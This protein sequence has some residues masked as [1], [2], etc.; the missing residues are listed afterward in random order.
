MAREGAAA[1]AG[2]S[3][4]GARQPLEALQGARALEGRT[5]R[6][7]ARS[8]LSLRRRGTL[9]Q[10]TL[11]GQEVTLLAWRVVMGSRGAGRA[12]RSLGWCRW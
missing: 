1:D 5:G 9:L 6:P 11:L 8:R 7:R 3:V 10:V 12:L 4:W 2:S